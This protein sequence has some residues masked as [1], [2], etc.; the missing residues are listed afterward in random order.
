MAVPAALGGAIFLVWTVA[1]AI[2]RNDKNLFP[3]ALPAI[4]GFAA[5]ALALVF[6]Y[7]ARSGR[8][9]AM[10]GAATIAV[11]ATLFT[12]LYPRVM[13][14][15]PSFDNSLTVSGTASSHYSLEVMSIAALILLPV[16]LLY[17]GWTYWVFRRRIGD[18]PATPASTV[19]RPRAALDPP[20]AS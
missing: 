7:R 19:D 20:G 5:L 16:V 10:T 2:D 18:E 1:V 12:A 8:A 15:N 6:L 11:V 13:V 17:Q 14:S 4:V 3:P 9:F